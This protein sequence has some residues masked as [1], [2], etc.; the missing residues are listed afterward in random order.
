MLEAASRHLQESGTKSDNVE[1]YKFADG[2]N[3]VKFALLSD[4]GKSI[5]HW[6]TNGKLLHLETV[7]DVVEFYLTPVENVT[8]YTE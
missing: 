6:P 5:K 3:S 1:Q 7:A 8:K 2:C 4:L